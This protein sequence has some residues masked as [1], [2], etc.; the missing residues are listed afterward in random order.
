MQIHDHDQALIRE[1]ERCATA[2]VGPDLVL[3]QAEMS[4]GCDVSRCHRRS[5]V[6]DVYDTVTRLYNTTEN[7]KRRKTTPAASNQA[8]G[9]DLAD[10]LTS[11]PLEVHSSTHRSHHGRHLSE[12]SKNP[13]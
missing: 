13:A 9:Y 10:P 8:L 3:P 4:R 7:A 6:D 1:E 11:N 12:R 2:S 5:T